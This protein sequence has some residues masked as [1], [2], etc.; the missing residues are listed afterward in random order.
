M[1]NT[2]DERIDDDLL[3]AYVLDALDPRDRDEIDIRLEHDEALQARVAPLARTVALL[4]TSVE[5]GPPAAL[6]AA[7][8][9]AATSVRAPAITA[10]TTTT[11]TTS[12]TTTTSA[13]TDELARARARRGRIRFVGPALLVAAALIVGLVLVVAGRSGNGSGDQYALTGGPGT[14]QVRV[15]DDRVVLEG[16][17]VPD[18]GTGADYQLWYVDGGSPRSVGVFH[19]DASGDVHEEFDVDRGDAALMAVTKEPAGGSAA[20][21]MPIVYQAE[22]A[23]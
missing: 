16:S 8:L 18:P 7:V 3:V 11:T 5:A 23:T 19:P 9:D 2:D 10:A 13:P 1:S 14:V 20:P 22:L 6:R 21:T 4:A 17:S 15:Y 12:P